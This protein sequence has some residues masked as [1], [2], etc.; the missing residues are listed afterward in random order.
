M[1]AVVAKMITAAAGTGVFF[2][3]G[4]VQSL[5]GKMSGGGDTAQTG[6]DHEHGFC[7]HHISF[8]G[9]R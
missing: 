8:A 4:D 3:H 6:A 7:W 5:P 2:E 1:M 9:R